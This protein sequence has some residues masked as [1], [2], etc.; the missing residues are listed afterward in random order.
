M[1]WHKLKFGNVTGN[2]HYDHVI[3]LP[4]QKQLDQT[5]TAR[6]ADANHFLCL[7]KANQLTAVDAANIKGPAP[8]S[9]QVAAK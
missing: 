9:G 5:A 3:F 4:L 1:P 8:S 6:V 2:E 7:Y